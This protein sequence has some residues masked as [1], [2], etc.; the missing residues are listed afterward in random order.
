MQIHPTLAES[1]KMLAYAADSHLNAITRANM[2]A[3]EVTSILTDVQNS[4]M[5]MSDALT[6]L[7]VINAGMNQ[8]MRELQYVIQGGIDRNDATN[9]FRYT[10]EYDIIA[11]GQML[12]RHISE[13][14]IATTDQMLQHVT[15]CDM[16][17]SISTTAMHHDATSPSIAPQSRKVH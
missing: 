10:N 14:I 1:L 13:L 7:G 4:R 15:G 6:E 16:A 3:S 12:I 11:A 9:L 5:S 8:R 2:M 17:T